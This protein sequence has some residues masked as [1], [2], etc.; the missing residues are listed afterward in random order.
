MGNSFNKLFSNRSEIPALETT[1]TRAEGGDAQAQ[2]SLGIKFANDGAA[3]D[4]TQA[5]Q[6]YLKAADQDHALAQFN[7]GIMYARGQGVL[8]DDKQSQVWIRKAAHL[9]DA[10]AQYNLGMRQHRISMGEASSDSCESRI[11]AYKWLR[12]A[13]AQGYAASE[14][15]CECVALGMT[16]EGVADADRRVAAFI[17]GAARG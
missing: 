10:G 15:G 8:R 2:F 6:W 17:P 3:Q 7:L 4:F 12:L 1:A 11:E 14:T 9:G 13:A 16:R 5:A